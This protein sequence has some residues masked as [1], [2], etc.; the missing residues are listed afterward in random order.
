MKKVPELSKQANTVLEAISNPER[1][2]ILR[3]LRS[4][5]A[6]LSFS[7][8]AELFSMNSNTLSRHLKILT[9][10]TL[11]WNT[12]ERRKGKDYSFYKL[13]GLGHKVLDSLRVP[14]E[15][16]ELT[17]EHNPKHIMDEALTLN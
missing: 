8:L 6:G 2:S 1:Y 16:T 12:Y 11:V 5:D 15:A 4:Y 10:A 9:H 14:L 17:V 3:T 7:Q 13:S